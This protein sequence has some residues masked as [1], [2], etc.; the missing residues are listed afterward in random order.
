M[1]RSVQVRPMAIKAS[2]VSTSSNVEAGFNHKPEG[3]A[4]D[5]RQAKG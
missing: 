4:D 3:K 1:K 2:K 5:G